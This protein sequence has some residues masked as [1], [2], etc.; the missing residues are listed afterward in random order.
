MN[1]SWDDVALICDQVTEACSGTLNTIDVTGY[2]WATIDDINA[3]FNSYWGFEPPM[4]GPDFRSANNTPWAPAFLADFQSTCISGLSTP[5]V[6]GN[7]RELESADSP[8]TPYL[9]D[10]T[11]EVPSG[12]VDYAQDESATRFGAWL[13]KNETNV[14]AVPTLSAHGLVFTILGLL[15]IATRGLSRR[16]GREE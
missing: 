7:S 10:G 8:Y 11:D 14:T 12:W 16:N 2:T 15:V 4:S 1:L 6:E 3:L 9:E 13:W 5:G